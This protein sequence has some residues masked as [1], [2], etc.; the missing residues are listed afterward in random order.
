MR[1][2]TTLAGDIIGP[3]NER[4][5]VDYFVMSENAKSNDDYILSNGTISF[6]P[7]ELLKNITAMVGT[8]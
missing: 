1:G 2:Q 8:C 3:V 7:G 6:D 4:L 5:I